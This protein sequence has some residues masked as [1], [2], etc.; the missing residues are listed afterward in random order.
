MNNFFDILSPVPG[1]PTVAVPPFLPIVSHAPLRP[2]DTDTPVELKLTLTPGRIGI[3]RKN[4]SAI[5][6]ASRSVAADGN[7]YLR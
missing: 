3:D 6:E 5:P 4:R 1:A 2:T 7:Q